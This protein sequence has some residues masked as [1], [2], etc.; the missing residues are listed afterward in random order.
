MSTKISSVKNQTTSNLLWNSYD[1]NPFNDEGI[2]KIIDNM[3]SV[4]IPVTSIPSPY[5]Q[6]HLFSTAFADVNKKYENAKK[7]QEDVKK[8]LNGT[9]TYHRAIS[10]C[11]DIF[12]LLY[13]YDI[14]ALSD[15]ISI[16]TWNQEELNLAKDVEIYL[17]P[18]NWD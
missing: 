2:S 11:L 1:G 18:P 9:T 17:P 3:D 12:E 5:A 16:K 13:S 4:E 8:V 14:L 10:D 15:Q 6:M 7:G